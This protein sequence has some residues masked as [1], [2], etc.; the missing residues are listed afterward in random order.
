MAPSQSV[1]GVEIEAGGDKEAETDREKQDIEH[2]F[3]PE[4][5]DRHQMP[6]DAQRFEMHRS[7][8]T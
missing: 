6:A 5:L 4:P 1:A 7:H 8:Q 2:G 3:A